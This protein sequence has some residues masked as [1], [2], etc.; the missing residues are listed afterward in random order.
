MSD[1]RQ[2]NGDKAVNGARNLQNVTS[3]SYLFSSQWRTSWAPILAFPSK[4]PFWPSW[5]SDL[6]RR[7]I[8]SLCCTTR[9]LTSGENI[10]WEWAAKSIKLILPSLL[11]DGFC[12]DRESEEELS[13]IESCLLSTFFSL[14]SFEFLRSLEFDLHRAPPLSIR[15]SLSLQDHKFRDFCHSSF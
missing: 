14:W 4:F 5:R 8:I 10:W 3:I 12:E 11:N 9:F 6:M 13:I 2:Q 1:I 15:S 7:V